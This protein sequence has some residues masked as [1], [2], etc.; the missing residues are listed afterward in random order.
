VLRVLGP[1]AA[2]VVRLLQ[3]RAPDTYAAVLTELRGMGGHGW[4]PADFTLDYHGTSFKLHVVG[5]HPTAREIYGR[6]AEGREIEEVVMLECV[7]RLVHR[8]ERPE[9]VDI[10]AFM[11]HYACYVARLLGDSSPTYAVESNPRFCDA[12]RRSIE[13]NAF[14]DLRVLQRV[15]SDRAEPASVRNEEV[16]FGSLEDGGSM[17]I[18]GDELFAREQMRP[19]ILKMDVHGAEGKVLRGLERVLAGPVEFLLL[20][21]HR[22][23]MLWKYS[24]DERPDGLLTYL[25]RLGFHLFHVAG[26]RYRGRAELQ[27]QVRAGIAYRPLEA[28]TRAPALFDRDHDVFLLCSKTADLAPV[29]GPPA[30]DPMYSH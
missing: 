13:L 28:A 15:L 9:F 20:E 2:R 10:G 19:K 14:L 12:I 24:G 4:A 26:H 5:G 11:G 17:A 21:L 27:Q 25:E 7:T 3:R 1:A 23:R 30:V 29:I 22:G 16:L 18:T 8:V 6:W